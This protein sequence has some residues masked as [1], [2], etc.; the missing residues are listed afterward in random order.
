VNIR[1]DRMAWDT[2]NQPAV[3]VTE[4]KTTEYN[5]VVTPEVS[6]EERIKAA[7]RVVD[8]L[9]VNPPDRTARILM[10]FRKLGHT[11]DQTEL[12]CSLMR[13]LV[14]IGRDA[15]PQICA[16]LDTTTEDRALRRLAFALR[17]I[18]DPRAVSALIRAIPRTLLPSSSD[19]GLLVADGAL[20]KFMQAHDLRGGE[21]GGSYFDFG[22]PVREITGALHEL[23]KQDL[24]DSE[25]F[26]LYR[27]SDPR[28]QALQ[29][30]LMAQQARRWQTW[31]ETHAHEFTDDGAYQKVGLPSNDELLPAVTQRL[32][33]K[34]RVG[35]G[36]MGATLSPAIQG[37]EHAWHFYDLDTGFRPRWPAHIPKDEA[38]IDQKQLAAWAAANGVDLMC[39]THRA[40]DG[41]ETFAL[42]SFELKAW[43]ISDR[44]LR[45]IDRLVAGGTLPAGRDV[46]ELLMHYDVQ[47]KRLVPN[48]N[49]AFIYV[50]REGSMGL[51]ST[52]DRVTQTADLT[53][54]AGRPPAGVGFHLGVRFDIKS[55]VP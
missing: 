9:P 32:G 24:G 14:A 49:G 1:G 21:R 8:S 33:P 18:G 27:S 22:R 50:T 19:Y 41:T 5:M 53:G 11:V 2:T 34:A 6:P 10:E 55:I 48:A 39:V 44:D 42:R 35:E 26:S 3:L 54:M 45:N 37:G 7:G 28:R 13:E 40:A 36:L 51:I 30:R 16:E 17:A 43:E 25:Y 20:T 52:T 12:W 15:V 29:R 38:R 31:W 23:T 47:S 46:G 4:G